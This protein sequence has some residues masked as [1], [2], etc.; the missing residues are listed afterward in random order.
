PHDS[1][2]NTACSAH[3]S[4][5]QVFDTVVQAEGTRAYRPLHVRVDPP[6]NA[7]Q[8]SCIHKYDGLVSCGIDAEGLGHALPA[9]QGADGTPGPRI[10]KIA[11]APQAAKH[12][13]PDQIIDVTTIRQRNTEDFQRPDTGDAV[14]LP[15]KRHVAEQIVERE[16]P[17]NGAQWQEVTGKPQRNRTQNIGSHESDG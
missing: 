1:A 2:P 6:R 12:A 17:C 5:E 16:A 14:M 15:Q 8:Q 11:C 10:Q 9:L 4:H 7:S 3:H 13:G